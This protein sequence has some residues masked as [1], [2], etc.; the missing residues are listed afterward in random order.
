[1]SVA[2]VHGLQVVHVDDHKT[3]VMPLRSGIVD[4]VLQLR[5]EEG[6]I[7]EPGKRISLQSRDVDMHHDRMPL[8][9]NLGWRNDG[10]EPVMK[11][12]E[13]TRIG[14]TK[15]RRLALENGSESAED[16]ARLAA[17]A[18]DRMLAFGEIILAPFREA[19]DLRRCNPF[20][21]GRDDIAARSD[22][23]HLR[24]DTVDQRVIVQH[25]ATLTDDFDSREVRRRG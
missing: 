1:M 15:A 13:R 24:V 10:L 11:S 12:I 17:T 2:V 20:T 18:R 7:G 16:R 25:L 9:P 19:A 3:G 21:V 23:R 22:N 5:V 4:R 8:A 6:A 14:A